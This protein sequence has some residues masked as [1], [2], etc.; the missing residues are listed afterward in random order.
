MLITRKL[1]FEENTQFKKR[2]ER[3]LEKPLDEKEKIDLIK[4]RWIFE[5]EICYIDRINIQKIKRAIINDGLRPTLPQEGDEF[6]CKMIAECWATGNFSSS[7]SLSFLRSRKTTCFFF[8]C[9]KNCIQTWLF[10]S[11]RVTQSST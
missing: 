5:G 9:I 2:I 6:I 11:Y 1:P 3:K 8:S 10:L 4:N 7:K